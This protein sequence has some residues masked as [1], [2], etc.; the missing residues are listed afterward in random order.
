MNPQDILGSNKLLFDIIL[1]PFHSSFPLFSGELS[2]CVNSFFIL[3][4]CLLPSC[5]SLETGFGSKETITPAIS[6]FVDDPEVAF[7]VL[8]AIL[9][10]SLD[11]LKLMRSDLEVLAFYVIV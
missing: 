4:M 2:V 9:K 6:K 8:D 1:Q 7:S 10:R 5:W 11:R 3:A